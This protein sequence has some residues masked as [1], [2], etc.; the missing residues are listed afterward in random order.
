MRFAW[1][2]LALGLVGCDGGGVPVGGDTDAQVED[3]ARTWAPTCTSGD[4]WTGG[5]HESPEMHPGRDCID[6]HRQ[7]GGPTLGIAGTVF[8]DFHDEDDCDGVQGVTVHVTDASGNVHD[9][10]TNAAGNFYSRFPVSTPFSASLEYQGHT[11]EMVTHPDSTSCNSCHTL[12]GRED[13]PG[14]IVAP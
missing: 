9:Y 8:S 6:C 7:E 12:A 14:R 10:T 4:R 1:G 5:D 3:T 13:A 11:S 2:A